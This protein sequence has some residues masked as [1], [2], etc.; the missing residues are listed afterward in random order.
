MPALVELTPLQTSYLRKMIFLLLVQMV[1]LL[2]VVFGIHRYAPEQYCLLTCDFWMD[3]I[4]YLLLA[5]VCFGFIFGFNDYTSTRHYWIRCTAFLFLGVLLAYVLAVQY[6]LMM[7]TSPNPAQTTRYFFIALFVTILIFTLVFTALP[8]LLN[9][10][11]TMAYLSIMLF[12]ALLVL[13]VVT[14]AMYPTR[15]VLILTLIVFLG[16]LVTD[17]T[18]LTYRCTTPGTHA[19]DPPTGATTLYLDLV[20][21]LQKLFMLLNDRT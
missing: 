10:T 5:L 7:R 16:Y 21:I 18:L 17:L 9:Y 19:C 12:G 13:L 1:V 20:N 2:V 6:N 15:A 14:L 4:L 11:A 3:I 8:I